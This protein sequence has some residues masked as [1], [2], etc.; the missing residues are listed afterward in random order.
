MSIEESV[1]KQALGL[2]AG[3]ALGAITGVASSNPGYGQCVPRTAIQVGQTAGVAMR[4]GASVS[5]AAAAG[6]AVLTAKA[7]AVGTAVVAA[8]PVI[9]GAA[10]VGAIGYGIYKLFSDE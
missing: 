2:G 9:A 5:G 3:A 8:A 1:A 4:N 7:A 10:V 6:A